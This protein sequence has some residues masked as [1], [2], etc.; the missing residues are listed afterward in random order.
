MVRC[1]NCEHA[2]PVNAIL[3]RYITLDIGMDCPHCG[4]TQYLSKDYR[5]R[6]ML[7]TL[8]IPL[9]LLIPALFDFSFPVI[10]VIFSAAFIALTFIHLFTLELA[11]EEETWRNSPYG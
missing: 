6:S 8:L 11:C 2:W 9:L 10:A 3:K 7:A 1:K 4:K 5:Q